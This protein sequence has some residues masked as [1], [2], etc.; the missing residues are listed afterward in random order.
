MTMPKHTEL[1]MSGDELEAALKRLDLATHREAAELFRM[2]RSAITYMV[3][4]RSTVPPALEAL[5][6]LLLDGKI[7]KTDVAHALRR[8]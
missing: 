3:N 1:P 7:T 2:H 8:R 5:V 6:R 4:G